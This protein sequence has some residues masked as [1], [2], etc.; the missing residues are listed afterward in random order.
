[1]APLGLRGA[2]VEE[3]AAG[4]GG[5][6]VIGC[7]KP[8]LGEVGLGEV[9]GGVGAAH[10]GGDPAGFEGG[11]DDGRREAAGGGAGEKGDVE[12]GVAVGLVAAPR[13]GV[14]S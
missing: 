5:D 7:G 8:G 2:L 9:A 11:G 6:R 13:D 1:M 12:F 3:I 4:G 10:F 14:P